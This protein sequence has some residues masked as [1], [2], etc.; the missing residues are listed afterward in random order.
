MKFKTLIMQN[1]TFDNKHN[2]KYNQKSKKSIKFWEKT[3]S[4]PIEP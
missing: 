2:D 1:I 4:K 3:K